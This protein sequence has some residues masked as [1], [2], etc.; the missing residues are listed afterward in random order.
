MWPFGNEEIVENTIT[1]HDVVSYSVDG[2]FVVILVAAVLIW[3]WRTNVR[4]L[5]SLEQEPRRRKVDV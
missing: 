3:K 4:R 1:A 2:A 5:K